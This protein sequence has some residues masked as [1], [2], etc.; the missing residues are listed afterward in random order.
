MYLVSWIQDRPGAGFL[1]PASPAILQTA[2]WPG[3]TPGLS[4]LSAAKNFEHSMQRSRTTNHQRCCNPKGIVSASPGLRGTSYPGWRPAAFPTPTGLR[5]VFK[6]WPQPR[7][8][9]LPLPRCPRV[10]RSSQPWAS[11]WNPFG[12][13]FWNFRKALSLG[14]IRIRQICKRRRTSMRSLI[15]TPLP[16]R[17]QAK[18]VP[19]SASPAAG[20]S[21]HRFAH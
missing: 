17:R 7:W 11:G 20:S 1:R 14:A 19:R 16:L 8:G 3:L 2:S 9:C 10:A 12:I 18:L 13:Q 21:A 15:L 5:L 4:T 6:V